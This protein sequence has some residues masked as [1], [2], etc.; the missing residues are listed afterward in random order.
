MQIAKRHK[1][2]RNMLHMAATSN[3]CGVFEGQAVRAVVV[4]VGP[5]GTPEGGSPRGA[6]ALPVLVALM[7]Q[8]ET[9]SLKEVL[10]EFYRKLKLRHGQEGRPLKGH[11]A[12]GNCLKIPSCSRVTACCSAL[13]ISSLL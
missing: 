10:E 4:S 11:S 7:T 5:P 6:A 1:D 8:A 3:V 12:V 2:G 13:D 9:D